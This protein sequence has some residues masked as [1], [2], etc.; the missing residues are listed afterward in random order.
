MNIDMDKT[1]KTK[2]FSKEVRP[3]ENLPESILE[4]INSQPVFISKYII[5]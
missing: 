3:D 4:L 2:H 1:V 5:D